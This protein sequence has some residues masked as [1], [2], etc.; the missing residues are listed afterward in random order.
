MLSTSQQILKAYL[1]AT[2]GQGQLNTCRSPLLCM[3]P[4]GIG[5]RV[6]TMHARKKKNE[7]ENENRNRKMNQTETQTLLAITWRRLASPPA[8]ESSI[9]SFSH[10]C[11]VM[12]MAE[13][14]P[15]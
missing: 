10:R 5:I 1:P 2:K 15:R 13:A 6:L 12:L 7:K 11:W 3:Q 4:I 9:Q 8:H 14:V